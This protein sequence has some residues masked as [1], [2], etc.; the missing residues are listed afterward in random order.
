MSSS[1]QILYPVWDKNKVKIKGSYRKYLPLE[2]KE[3]NVD[4]EAYLVN[5]K[6]P[7]HLKV[8]M[9]GHYTDSDGKLNN[10]VS[11]NFINIDELIYG[12][13]LTGPN[14][15]NQKIKI[16]V[17]SYSVWK[18]RNTKVKLHVGLVMAHIKKPTGVNSR[19]T[20]AQDYKEIIYA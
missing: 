3:L 13:K 2:E 9:S 16:K 10:T 7:A 11:T 4:L 5:N 15:E 18:E 8:W 20:I 17:P 14:D 1:P 12:N 6:K 19:N